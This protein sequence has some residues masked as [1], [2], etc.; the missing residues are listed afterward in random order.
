MTTVYDK[1][2]RPAGLIWAIASTYGRSVTY[3]S[4][5]VISQLQFGAAPLA[6]EITTFDQGLTSLRGKPTTLA[7]SLACGTNLFTLGYEY[8]PG[9]LALAQCATNNLAP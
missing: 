5:G 2:D 8:C 1:L 6:T 4:N 3:A 7:V 9:N